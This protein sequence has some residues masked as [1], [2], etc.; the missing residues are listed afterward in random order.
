VDGVKL[1]PYANDPQK[2]VLA[3]RLRE[4]FPDRL[5]GA[6]GGL[7]HGNLYE[8]WFGANVDLDFAGSGIDN[9]NQIPALGDAFRQVQNGVEAKRTSQ[10]RRR[11]NAA[12]L[13]LGVLPM[14]YLLSALMGSSLVMADGWRRSRMGGCRST[15]GLR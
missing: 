9:P 10:A 15:R 5:I 4:V 8:E 14:A 6:A 7:K 12:L 11:P 3:R 13:W 2:A 1:K